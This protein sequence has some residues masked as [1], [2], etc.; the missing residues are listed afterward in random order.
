VKLKT[1]INLTKAEVLSGNSSIDIDIKYAFA[2]DLMSDTL[3][4]VS[5]EEEPVLLIS[6]VTNSS[7]IRTAVILDIPV[8]LIVRGKNIPDETVRMARE[9]NIIFL[10]TKH[11]MFVTCGILYNAGMRGAPWKEK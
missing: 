10:R 6:G 3:F 9:N 7:V 1:I 8:V 5:R 2:A 11:I 4:I